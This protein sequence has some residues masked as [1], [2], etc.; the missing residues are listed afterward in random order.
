MPR[1]SW[2]AR[3]ANNAGPVSTW[4]GMKP[5]RQRNLRVSA[6]GSM[7]LERINQL[8]GTHPRRW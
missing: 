5:A 6:W 4:S 2:L 1:A 8:Q 3:T 7:R